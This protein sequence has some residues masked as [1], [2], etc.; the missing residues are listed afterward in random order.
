MKRFFSV[1]L[2]F[3]AILITGCSGYSSTGKLTVKI[4]KNAVSKIEREASS[5]NITGENNLILN[6]NILGDYSDSRTVSLQDETRTVFSAIPEGSEIHAEASV[7]RADDRDKKA[8]L[9]GTSE[10][11][12]IQ[13]GENALDLIL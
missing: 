5:G 3:A 13:E 6:I 10:T 4:D 11:I 7:Y 1:F 2:I 12:T 8:V 9:K